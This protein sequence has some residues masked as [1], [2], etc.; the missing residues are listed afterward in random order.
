MGEDSCPNPFQPCG[1]VVPRYHLAHP[2]A[3]PEDEAGWEAQGTLRGRKTY[4]PATAPRVTF[5]I[6]T[7]VRQGTERSERML[8]DPE[9]E[10]FTPRSRERRRN[11]FSV[12]SPILLLHSGP[13]SKSTEQY[14]LSSHSPNSSTSHNRKQKAHTV[15]KKSLNWKRD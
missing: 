15:S 4:V 10:R 14:I 3:S 12:D 13:Q 2:P 11:P 9:R 1:S 8:L 5:K 7:L 6:L